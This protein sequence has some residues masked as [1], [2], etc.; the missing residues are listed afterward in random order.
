MAGRAGGIHGPD[1]DLFSALVQLGYKLRIQQG[2]SLAGKA[3]GSGAC[4]ERSRSASVSRIQP[5]D[6]T[7]IALQQLLPA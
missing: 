7:R 2:M 3:I 5:L 4:A 1:V 6:L